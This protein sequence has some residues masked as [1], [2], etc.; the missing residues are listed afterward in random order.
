[1]LGARFGPTHEV[2]RVDLLT[3]TVRLPDVCAGWPE[4]DQLLAIWEMRAAPTP[5]LVMR[6]RPA[7]AGC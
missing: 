3:R 6:A 2:T 7:A 4:I 5:W 1:M